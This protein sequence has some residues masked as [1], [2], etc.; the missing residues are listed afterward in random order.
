VVVSLMDE[1]HLDAI[2][3]PGRVAKERECRSQVFEFAL[4]SCN[5]MEHPYPQDAVAAEVRSEVIGPCGRDRLF[6]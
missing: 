3:Y 2:A 1:H 5:P 4:G 6:R